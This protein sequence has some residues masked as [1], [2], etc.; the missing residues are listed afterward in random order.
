MKKGVRAKDKLRVIA[1]HRRPRN[2]HRIVKVVSEEEKPS[3]SP[4]Q[5]VANDIPHQT[6]TVKLRDNAG[7][8][9]A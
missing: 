3:A 8:S 5:T 2:L 7:F 1:G 4:T 6:L 9:P